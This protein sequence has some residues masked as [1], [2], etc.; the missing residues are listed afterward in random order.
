M[1]SKNIQKKRKF[2]GTLLGTGSFGCVVNPPIRCSEPNIPS[3]AVGKLFSDPEEAD[4]EFELASFIKRLDP[5][6]EFTNPITHRCNVPFDILLESSD[7]QECAIHFYK[8]FMFPSGLIPFDITQLVY[9]YQGTDMEKVIRRN[10]F[11]PFSQYFVQHLLSIANGIKLFNVSGII[12]GDIKPANVIMLE[13][14]KSVLIDFGM[15]RKHD[16]M[17]TADFKKW[18]WLAASEYYISPP[19]YMIH[20]ILTTI[21][22]T[23]NSKAR[24]YRWSVEILKS[25][26]D[27]FLNHVT[28]LPED[29]YNS[30]FAY[31]LQLEDFIEHCTNETLHQQVNG[32]PQEM[33]DSI[34]KKSD[35]YQFG[36]LMLASL[37]KSELPQDE[38][39]I[40]L[41]NNMIR[42]IKKC[43]SGNPLA[44][45]DIDEV[46]SSLEYMMG[47]NDDI[48]SSS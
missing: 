6:G 37:R 43:T 40:S 42:L 38:R 31:I 3:T 34:A 7:G 20:Y 27:L 48:S 22:E 4:K 46:I 35:V 19:E 32:I 17:Y 36:L 26:V 18:L 1:V 28:H 16:T 30:K 14:G 24:I 41:R 13:S 2:G 29:S 39:T 33:F 10:S 8:K 5:N 11:T 44:R 23:R 47:T 45:P 25:Y 9:A 15:T 21:P 12:H